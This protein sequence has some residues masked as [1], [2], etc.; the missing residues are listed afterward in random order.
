[1]LHD[2][3]LLCDM[4][5]GRKTFSLISILNHCQRP[6]QSQLFDTTQAGSEL[7]ES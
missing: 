3:E 4:T 2:D 5:D 7:A 1:M 6:S